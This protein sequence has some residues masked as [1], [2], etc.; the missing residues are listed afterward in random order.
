LSVATPP[1]S[2]SSGEDL[3]GTRPAPV[4]A[5]CPLCGAPLDHDQEW[6]MRCG[7]AARTRLAAPTNW[8][9]P[10]VALALVVTFALGGLAAALVKLASSNGT[11]S[12]AAP[13]TTTITTPAGAAAPAATTPTLT[14]SPALTAAPTS[15]GATSAPASPGALNPG[16]PT[17]LKPSNP[18]G[19]GTPASTSPTAT[20]PAQAGHRT[21]SEEALRKAGFLL[22]G[23]K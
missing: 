3:G 6:C 1:I 2:G 15:P 11:S 19:A 4:D 17:T 16:T 20:A 7:A 21:P 14:T 13:I 18:T 10:I 22:R 5:A 12:A 23:G 8:K 9:A